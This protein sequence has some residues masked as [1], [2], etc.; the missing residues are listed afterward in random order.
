M[1]DSLWFNAETHYRHGHG[2]REA[3][4]SDIS[5]KGFSLLTAQALQLV[6]RGVPL[7]RFSALGISPSGQ[8][9]GSPGSP[10]TTLDTVTLS[11]EA[12]RFLASLENDPDRRTDAVSNLGQFLETRQFENLDLQGVNFIGQD[13]SGAVFRNSNL[14]GAN[15]TGANLSNATFLNTTVNGATFNQANLTAADL[16]GAI[17]LSQ[18]AL[19]NTTLIGTQLPPGIGNPILSVTGA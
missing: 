9:T 10:I 14:D 1:W 13:L 7:T 5:G 11:E 4:V 2:R 12:Q 17:G 19:A 3:P 18:S 8:N 6:V 16:R 15:F